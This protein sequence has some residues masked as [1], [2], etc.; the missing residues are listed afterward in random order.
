MTGGVNRALDFGLGRAIR[1]HRIQ[2]YDAWHGVRCGR[3]AGFLDLN[4]FAPLVIA[5]LGAGAMRHLFLVAIGTL[6]KGMLRQGIVRPPRGRPLLRVPPFWIRHEKFLTT[7]QPSRLYPNFDRY[8]AKL[9][10]AVITLAILTARTE[11]AIQFLAD[12]SQSLPARIFQ[13]LV[14]RTWLSVAVAAAT[15]TQS[16][17][18]LTTQNFQRDREQ[19]LLANSV[20][21]KQ[22]FAL[23]VAD[24]GFR[25]GYRQLFVPGVGAQRAIQQIKAARHLLDHRLD[26]ARAGQRE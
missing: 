5:T 10:S 25:V 18:V 16:L 8:I 1:T 13:R 14:T 22:A 23:I 20:F 6:G 24:F 15:G 19:H 7:G 9:A 11:S 4:H 12:L 21:Q 26:T 3:L 17:A 2:S